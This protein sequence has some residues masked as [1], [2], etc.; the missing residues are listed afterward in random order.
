MT[1]DVAKE[2]IFNMKSCKFFVRTI[3]LAVLLISFSQVEATDP[4]KQE[5]WDQQMAIP[6][7]DEDGNPLDP[8]IKEAHTALTLLGVPSIGG[9]MSGEY[10]A[11]YCIFESTTKQELGDRISTLS[12]TLVTERQ[13]LEAINPDFFATPGWED[14]PAAQLWKETD[15]EL[16]T[17]LVQYEVEEISLQTQLY[18]LFEKFYLTH[19]TSYDRLLTLYEGEIRSHGG[20]RQPFRTDAEKIQKFADYQQ[21]MASFATF[22]KAEFFGQ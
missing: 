22:L 15:A 16:G 12:A 3:V 20:E 2:G 7:T 1:Q 5:L 14:D 10:P 19:Y 21:E 9:R 8:V 17:V 6:L 11:V 18:R 13:R 4:S